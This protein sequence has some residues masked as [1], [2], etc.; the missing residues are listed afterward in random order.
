MALQ[1]VMLSPDVEYLRSSNLSVITYNMEG[2]DPGTTLPE[3]RI[4]AGLPWVL[5]CLCLCLNV[6]VDVRV[7]RHLLDDVAARLR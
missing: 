7:Y 1:F 3:W 5:L 2:M 4:T 6:D